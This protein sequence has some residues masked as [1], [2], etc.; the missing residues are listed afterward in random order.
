[1]KNAVYV[2]HAYED[3]SIADAI[4]GKLESA[5]LKCWKATL[6]TATFDGLQ[7]GCDIYCSLHVSATVVGVLGMQVSFLVSC[8]HNHEPSIWKHISH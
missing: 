6:G 8:C 1:M 5:H 4:Y 7:L 3:K 2:S